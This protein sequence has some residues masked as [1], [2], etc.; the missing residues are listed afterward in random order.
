MTPQLTEK[1]FS[2]GANTIF[3]LNKP[4]IKPGE[5]ADLTVFDPNA[6]WVYLQTKIKS[7]SNNNPLI[8]K[9]LKGKAIATIKGNLIFAEN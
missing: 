5:K 9:K 2:Q 8:G 1:I 7:K 6:E 4:D 3:G